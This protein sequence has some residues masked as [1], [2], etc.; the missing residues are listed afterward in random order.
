MVCF[1]FLGWCG[2]SVSW[3]S[4]CSGCCAFCLSC[5]ACS[6]RCCLIGSTY[7]CFFMQMLCV[8]S[9]VHPVVIR[10]AVFCTVCSLFVFVSD[11]IGDQ[12]VLSYSSV[13]LVMAV[14]VLSSVSLDFPQ[15]VVVSAF[16]IIV[17]FFALSVVFC[18]CFAKVCLGSTLVSHP[19]M[20]HISRKGCYL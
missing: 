11:I 5:D 9:R 17:V 15:C 2:C 4:V 16:S 14:Y 12:I 8:V 18:I 10:S 7:A 3:C 19:S 20:L 1:M 6:A 13:V